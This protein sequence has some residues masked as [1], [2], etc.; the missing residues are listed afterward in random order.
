MPSGCCAA[1]SMTTRVY[2]NL[3]YDSQDHSRSEKAFS[4]HMTKANPKEYIALSMPA[5]AILT[6]TANTSQQSPGMLDNMILS[7]TLASA[8]LH[9]LS[10]LDHMLVCMLLICVIWCCSFAMLLDVSLSSV[11]HYLAGSD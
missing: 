1:G 10:G 9:C 7:A 2:D 11:G 6:R 3:V 4:A 8:L 5:A